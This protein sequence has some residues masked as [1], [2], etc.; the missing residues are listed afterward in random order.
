MAAKQNNI[1]T[2]R[3]STQVGEKQGLNFGTCHIFGEGG[4]IPESMSEQREGRLPHS[5]KTTRFKRRRLEQPP[6]QCL[7]QVEDLSPGE[8]QIVH[9][10]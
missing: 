5:D 4:I 3:D 9:Q 10:T 2:K 1:K 8:A 7:L 6:L